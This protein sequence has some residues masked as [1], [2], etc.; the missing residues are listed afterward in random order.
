MTRRILDMS[1]T[2]PT[3]GGLVSMA[4]CGDV[5]RGPAAETVRALED[6]MLAVHRRITGCVEQPDDEHPTARASGDSGRPTP[7][8]STSP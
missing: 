6:V 2:C 3:C 5:Q 4:V 1:A 7:A 8:G